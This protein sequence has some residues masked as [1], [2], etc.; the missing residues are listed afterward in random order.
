[1]SISY[2][3]THGLIFYVC[4]SMYSPRLKTT[5]PYACLIFFLLFIKKKK[6]DESLK[7]APKKQI[8]A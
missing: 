3:D 8:L 4:Y 2:L 7:K 1:M 6:E 5:K